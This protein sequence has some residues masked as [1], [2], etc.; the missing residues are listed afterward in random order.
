MAP[1]TVSPE[2]TLI[3]ISI[4]TPDGKLPPAKV[5]IPNI[6]MRM[7]D[8]VAP[9]HQ[10]CNGIVGLAIRQEMNRGE[11]VSCRKG[12]GVCCCQLV[13]LSPPEAFFLS[14]FIHRMPP[15]RHARIIARFQAIKEAMDE[16]G[17]TERVKKIETTN[18]HQTLA[19]DYF[20]MGISC[21]FLEEQSCSI[22]SSRPFA[23]REYNVISPPEYCADPFKKGV[24]KIKISRNMTTATARLAAELCNV[25]A[26]LVPMTL[27]LEWTSENEAIGLRTWPGVWLFNRMMQ[28]ATGADLEN[29][30]P[31]E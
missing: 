2:I 10:L 12:C 16:N 23:C 30:V 18:E 20:R 17:L 27:A 11:T 15:E 22:H 6:P 4:E 8:L 26:M 24:K 29:I 5:G 9:M 28:F 19:Y 14:D 25:P 1:E 3:T 21:P 7:A 31:E 13:P